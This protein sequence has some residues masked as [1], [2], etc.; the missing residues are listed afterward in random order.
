VTVVQWVDQ[1]M[2]QLTLRLVATESHPL[3]DLFVAAFETAAEAYRAVEAASGR[4]ERLSQG[5]PLQGEWPP[6][7]CP[8]SPDTSDTP[9]TSTGACGRRYPTVALTNH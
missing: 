6:S 2:D 5:L 7:S 3:H 1:V 4:R 8:R 9:V